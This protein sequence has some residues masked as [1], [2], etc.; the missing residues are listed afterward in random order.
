M[1]IETVVVLG[2][3]LYLLL[4]GTFGNNRAGVTVTLDAVQEAFASSD[5]SEWGPRY[6][7]ALNNLGKKAFDIFKMRG[8]RPTLRSFNKAS[9]GYDKLMD[10]LRQ[11][12][13]KPTGRVLSLCCGRG[14]WE[15]VIA[16]NPPV[17]HITSVTLGPGPGHEGHE[18]F[19]KIHFP[20]REKIRVLYGDARQ[21]PVSTHDV[22]LFDGGESHTDAEL[23]EARFYSLFYNVVMRQ[24]N[25]NTKHFVLKILTP[26]SPRIQRLLEEIQ[27]MTG[28]GALFRSCHSRL[29]TLELYFVSTA[30]AP[31]KAR[32]TALLK[33]IV[34]QGKMNKVLQAQ[35]YDLG[36]T[37][38]RE[39]I[40]PKTIPLLKPLDMT[41]SIRELGPPLPEQGM[42]FNHWETSGVYPF[43]SQGS[44]AMKYNRYAMCVLRRLLSTVPGFD[45]WK[46]TDTTP[47]GFLGVFN[48]KVDMA[49][50]ENHKYERHLVE[51]YEGLAHHFLRSG[52]RFRELDWTEVLKQANKQGAPGIID[53]QFENVG[54]FLSTPDWV[55]RVLEARKALEKGKPIGGIFNTIGKREKKLSPHEMKGSR[56]VAYLPIATRLLELK[57]FGKLLELTKPTINHFGVGGMGLHDLGMRVQE[58]WQGHAV[59][60]DIAGFDTRIGLYFLSLENH[61]IRMLGGGEIHTLMYRLYAYPHILIPMA[62][63]FVRSQLLKGRGQRMSGTNVTYSMNT[64]TRIC[65]CLLQYAIAKDIPLNELHDWTMQMMKQNSPLQGVV[66]GDDASFTSTLENVT[67]LSNTAHVLEEVG[68]PRKDIPI[69][70]PSPVVNKI[71]DVDFCSH[72]YEKITYYDA[73]TGQTTHR[74]MP[75]RDLTQILAKSTI[76]I[77]GKDASLDDMAWLSAQ[78]NNLLV[79]YSHLRTAR[80]VGF[81]YKAIVHPNALLCDTGG[82][83]R[84]TPWMEPG[85]ILDVMN[86]IL[87]GESTHYP[88]ENFRVHSWKHVG[89]LKPKRELVYDPETFSAGRAYWRS[90]LRS[91]VGTGISEFNTGGDITVLDNWR[92]HELT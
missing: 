9:R 57:L 53:T 74:Y 31:V 59:S 41:E 55:K 14:G 92:R 86:K 10:I 21:F 72:H 83:L 70:I 81:G 30:P 40:E 34:E 25:S 73:E 69:N 71:E 52:F 23:E 38:S 82:F 58:I 18:A 48:K 90:K 8:V 45:H 79:N 29:S 37:F 11:T 5:I 68:M 60:D 4:N 51:I 28:R 22:L 64:I 75:T 50:R 26:T 65:V 91:D 66:S 76:K 2:L 17:I 19:T 77:G 63:E 16:N 78:G 84:P 47:K 61:F 35:N 3:L 15:Q 24:I 32:A 1:I 62:S 12:K 7:R 88:V 85:D 87:F 54:Q 46:T 44:T 49:P 20:G 80:A 56:M 33:D 42:E 43:G 36:F 39:K 6:K 67:Q 89:F 13:I 27:R